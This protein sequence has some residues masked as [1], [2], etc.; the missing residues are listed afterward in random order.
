[1][2]VHNCAGCIGLYEDKLL[3]VTNQSKEVV[4]VKGHIEKGE[5]PKE[6]AKREFVEETGYYDFEISNR[7]V[8][9]LIYTRNI[10]GL[11]E[12]FVIR[13]YVAKLN[14]LAQSPKTA[15]DGKKL[16]NTWVEYTK[17]EEIVTFKNLIPVIK[18]LH[19]LFSSET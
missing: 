3:F 8:Y 14:S 2:K 7:K 17:A 15:E 18:R 4:L 1:M 10:N 16:D 5:S 11:K 6:A 13:V 19:K 12:K 9:N